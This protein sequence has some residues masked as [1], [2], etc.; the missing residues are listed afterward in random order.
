MLKEII[1]LLQVLEASRHVGRLSVSTNHDLPF[2][3]VANQCEALL[4]GK[5]QKLSVCMSI[6][7]QVS[8]LQKDHEQLELSTV[9]QLEMAQVTVFGMDSWTICQTSILPSHEVMKA[10]FL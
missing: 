8:D 1:Y 10:L 7:Q 6:H 4:M 2:K 5:Q 3:A 9:K